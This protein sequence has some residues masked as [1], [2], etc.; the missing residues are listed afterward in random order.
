MKPSPPRR[1]KRGLDLTIAKRSLRERSVIG[2]VAALTVLACAS[3]MAIAAPISEAG[4]S[5]VPPMTAPCQLLVGYLP[6]LDGGNDSQLLPGFQVRNNVTVGDMGPLWNKECQSPAFLAE[7]KGLTRYQNLS[8]SAFA[9]GTSYGPAGE[10]IGNGFNWQAACGGGNPG[11]RNQ[12]PPLPYNGSGCTYSEI[13]TFTLQL[14]GASAVSGPVLSNNGPP[15]CAGCMGESPTSSPA[16]LLLI[17]ISLVVVVATVIVTLRRWPPRL[18][19]TSLPDSL[20]PDEDGISDESERP[21]G[22]SSPP[23]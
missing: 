17:I 2:T 22:P 1:S 5:S 3:G 4:S 18:V 9:Y 23:N 20:R 10:G 6:E 8:P 15:N 21:D 16:P 12:S 13:W 11:P 7:Y 19:E 14:N